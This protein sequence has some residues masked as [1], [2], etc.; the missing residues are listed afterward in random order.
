MNYRHQREET[1]W[2]FEMLFLSWPLQGRDFLTRVRM[3]S[4][5]SRL[6]WTLAGTKDRCWRQGILGTDLTSNVPQRGTVS[7]TAMKC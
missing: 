3:E 6:N 2:W 5:G 4:T 7:P 1:A